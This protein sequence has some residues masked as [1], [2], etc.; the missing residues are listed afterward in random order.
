MQYF[1]SR[2]T[3]LLIL[4][5]IIFSGAI[6]QTSEYKKV[7][8]QKGDG[9]YSLLR[10]N[11]LD[12]KIYFDK[13]IGLNKDKLDKNLN[14]IKGRYYLLPVKIS[15]SVEKSNDT[16]VF[17]IF[18]KDYEEVQFKDTKLQGAV[19]YIVG[20]HGGPDPGAVGKRNGHR[21]C[22]DEYAY[23]VALRLARKLLEHNA[24][25]YLITRDPNDGIRDESY[26]KCDKDEVC[27]GNRKIPINQTKRLK[28]RTNEV[29]KLSKKYKGQYQRMI[30]LHVDSRYQGQNVDIFFYHHSKSSSG[31]RLCNTLLKTIKK[32]YQEH[33][34]GRGYYGNVSDRSLYILRNTNPVSAF[35]ELGNINHDRDQQRLI[36]MD[37]RQAIA[38]WLTLGLINDFNNSRK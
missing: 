6:A 26:L 16:G 27:W 20:G 37:N 9:V 12:P 14:L 10:K 33:Q 17:P 5:L 36:I 24:T 35:I 15:V 23:D 13:F 19:F 31:K 1:N 28:Q 38:N 30:V 22:E 32:K 7:K 25:V 4:L 18:G 2:K 34:P 11:N 8:A 21:L 29:N 3:F